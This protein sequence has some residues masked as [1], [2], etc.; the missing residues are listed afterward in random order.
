MVSHKKLF[1]TCPILCS[2]IANDLLNCI[3]CFAPLVADNL[4]FRQNDKYLLTIF[5]SIQR[6]LL[7]ISLWYQNWELKISATKLA[8]VLFTKRRN[9][10]TMQ[11]LLN[12][13]IIAF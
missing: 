5:H 8:A 10:P 9:I 11:F 2:V 1:F 12:N 4:S 7:K 3:D 6:N 13:C